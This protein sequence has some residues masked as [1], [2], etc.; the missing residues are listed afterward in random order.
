MTSCVT[1][2]LS[3]RMHRAGMLHSTRHSVHVTI[4]T[5]H[6]HCR[7][8]AF[9][10]LCGSYH[11]PSLLQVHFLSFPAD[12]IHI[13][14]A[15]ECV[16]MHAASICMHQHVRIIGARTC[17]TCSKAPSTSPLPRATP[18]RTSFTSSSGATSKSVVGVP[19]RHVTRLIGRGGC[20]IKQARYGK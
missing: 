9:I 13:S 19:A 8:R 20:N 4:R 2:P 14:H 6:P 12:M 5:A 11:P 7:V 17:L 18:T 15:S 10:I 16:S 1:L 3:R